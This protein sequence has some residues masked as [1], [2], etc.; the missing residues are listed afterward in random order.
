MNALPFVLLGRRVAFQPDIGTSAS[1]LTY[2]TTLT[3]PGQILRDPE[4]PLNE[5]E[6]QML[7]NKVKTTTSRPANQTSNH[8]KPERPLQGLPDGITHVYVRQHHTK[9]LQAP[10]EGPFKVDSKVSK[11]TIK[12]EVG[13]FQD[14]SKRFEIRHLNDV[15]ICHPK[16]L[17]AEASRPKL[18]R[19]S[20]SWLRWAVGVLG[21]ARLFFI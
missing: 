5:E 10:F 15:K 8:S 17:A 14:G 4:E 18:G 21:A 1:E 12:I 19:P 3:V 11:S 16:S 13:R 6:L 9:G 20:S 7:L 2:G